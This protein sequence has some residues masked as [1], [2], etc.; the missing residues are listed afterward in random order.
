[1]TEEAGEAILASEQADERNLISNCARIQWYVSDRS[2]ECR[3][4]RE[5]ERPR[6]QHTPYTQVVPEF[7]TSQN[8][9][10]LKRE[11]EAVY[12]F[13][14]SMA[15]G[16]D[17]Q[18]GLG[19]KL[20]F[21]G[22][23]DAE[24]CRLLRAANIAGA[25]SLAASAD[26]PALRRAMRE[27][28][29]DFV[30]TDLDEA[31]RILKNEIRKRRPVAVGVSLTPAAIAREMIERGV[32]PDLLAA[33]FAPDVGIDAFR[34]NGARTVEARP[35]PE[36]SE[37]HFVPVVPEWAQ[38]MA[39][40]DALL[41]GCFGEDDPLNRRWVQTA[42]KYLSVQARRIRVIVCDADAA[43]RVKRHGLATRD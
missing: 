28:A 33:Q 8:D 27:G 7:T 32:Q 24:G 29:L 31:L 13:Y 14:A 15:H 22:E 39:E 5:L 35:I 10:A 16:M 20:L 40:L 12:G 1:L 3:A 17:P 23:P 38:R 6:G 30:V 25:A 37:F 41:L 21:A 19:G 34:E 2:H 18:D 43:R 42:P 36:G 4:D 11:I 26:A 9:S